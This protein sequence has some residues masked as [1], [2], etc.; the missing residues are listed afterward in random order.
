M[1]ARRNKT[2]GGKIIGDLCSYIFSGRKNKTD[3][4]GVF[5][6]QLAAFLDAKYVLLTPTGRKGLSLI[7]EYY[8]FPKGAQIILPAY[9]LKDL[10]FMIQEKGYA[11]VFVD[12][13]PYTYNMDAS[14]VA[15]KITDKT[16]MVIATHLFGMPCEID[17]I[18]EICKGQGV[19]V[20]ED[21]AHSLGA[22][23]KGKRVGAFADAAFFSF[24]VSKPVNTFGGGAVWGKF[25]QERNKRIPAAEKRVIR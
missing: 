9:T 25:Y 15:A 16:V 7:L 24:E 14:L 13:D 1:I 23:F 6:K 21:C 18:V 22:R 19:V 20:I 5:E 8:R 10:V 12:I 17:K 11:P 2:C 4:V 3:Y